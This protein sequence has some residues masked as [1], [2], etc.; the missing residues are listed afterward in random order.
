[1]QRGSPTGTFSPSILASILQKVSP[2]G[3]FP[4]QAALACKRWLEVT[5]E[6]QQVF[7]PWRRN[8]Y[9]QAVP[10]RDNRHLTN[11]DAT[12]AVLEEVASWCPLL[13]YMRIEN[14]GAG[15]RRG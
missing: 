13:A 9:S 6:V 4:L 15:T 3:A 1:V 8:P 11:Y 14:T 12:D 7:D 5:R 2:E 10:A